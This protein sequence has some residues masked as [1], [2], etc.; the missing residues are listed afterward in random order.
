MQP[1]PFARKQ[2]P[3][4]GCCQPFSISGAYGLQSLKCDPLYRAELIDVFE[5]ICRR[6]H[7]HAPGSVDA[8]TEQKR[9]ECIPLAQQLER[10]DEDFERERL[11]GLDLSTHSPRSCLVFQISV[12]CPAVL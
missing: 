5:Q 11:R 8:T 2:R 9:T 4:L 12:R 3:I 1:K 7:H 10:P 6:G